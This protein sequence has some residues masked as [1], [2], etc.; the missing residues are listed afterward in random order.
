MA[1]RITVLRG[2]GWSGRRTPRPRRAA[3]REAHGRPRGHLRDRQGA[4]EPGRGGAGGAR[5]RGRRRPRR[6][7]V[8]GRD[9]SVAPARSSGWRESRATASA[10]WSRQSPGCAQA[11]GLVAID[12]S[13]RHGRTPRESRSWASATCPRTATSMGSSPRSHRRERRA[14]R[15]LPT[16]VRSPRRPAARRDRRA[17]ARPGEAL[18]RAHAGH[19]PVGNLSGG[20]QQKVVVARELSKELCCWWS[21]SPHAGRRRLDRVHPQ[22]DRRD[23]RRGRGGAAG[24]GRAR[25]DPGAGR[26]DRRALPRGA[27]RRVRPGG[28]PPASGRAPHGR[29]GTCADR[30]RRPG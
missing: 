22:A 5:P 19:H 24:V 6:R 8:A 26:H 25:R 14:Q 7:L 18:R 3:P 2:G 1:D 12:G 9:L 11:S 27:G 29:G 28:R 30:R 16:A 15:V 10:S 23:A 20:N 17:G 21:P 13:R 4:R